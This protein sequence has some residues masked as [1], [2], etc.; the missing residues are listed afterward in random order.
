VLS[1][2]FVSIFPKELLHYNSSHLSSA[3]CISYT[4][5]SHSIARSM[6]GLPCKS[7]SWFICSKLL[8]FRIILKSRCLTKHSFLS[9]IGILVVDP[10]LFQ[11]HA[12][13][14]LLQTTY[15]CLIYILIVLILYF[16]S[17]RFELSVVGNATFI[18][19]ELRGHSN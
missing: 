18:E 13:K 8:I 7:W 14:S 10:M 15:Y 1:S 3:I 11:E 4:P 2:I 19:T 9:C 17:P 5:M 16:Q 12:V 6:L